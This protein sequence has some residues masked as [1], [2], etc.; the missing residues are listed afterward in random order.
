M[1]KFQ[2][3]IFVCSNQ[4]SAGHPRGCCDAAG[5]DQLRAALKAELK[6]RDLT[7]LVRANQA[8]CLDQC[9]YGPVLVIY[10]QAIWYG[11]VQLADV[12]RIVEQ[13]IVQ[14]IILEDLRIPDEVLNTKG[15]KVKFAASDCNVCES[16]LSSPSEKNE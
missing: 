12:P 6:R 16:D 4:R 5:S 10:P 9:E 11:N 13:T 8:G 1:P 14:G 3:H 2:Q 15:G 7:P